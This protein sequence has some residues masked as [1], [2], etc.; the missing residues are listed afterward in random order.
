M[1]N[2]QLLMIVLFSKGFLSSLTAKTPLRRVSFA[3]F[4]S[5]EFKKHRSSPKID[6][7]YHGTF[8]INSFSYARQN[9]IVKEKN[10]NWGKAFLFYR[11]LSQRCIILDYEDQF[12]FY[13]AHVH[14]IS[15][16]F[17]LEDNNFKCP[18]S[19]RFIKYAGLL[20]REKLIALPI[21]IITS[22]PQSPVA[23]PIFSSGH[24]QYFSELSQCFF[25][26]NQ[27]LRLSYT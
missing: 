12:F 2:F 27:R 11:V 16:L 9:F 7:P 24:N 5:R 17:C 8:L 13:L 19:L 23:R 25:S 1:M 18:K 4:S 20:W 26:R 14:G 10:C 21:R 15:R 3:S 6:F 22:D